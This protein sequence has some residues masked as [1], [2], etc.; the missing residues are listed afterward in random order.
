MDSTNVAGL[1]VTAPL[2]SCSS[3]VGALRARALRGEDAVS[4]AAARR[5]GLRTA[6]SKHESKAQSQRS[7]IEE[8]EIGDV[9][10]REL[11]GLLALVVE[12]DV[13]DFD[14]IWSCFR[15]TG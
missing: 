8:G 14:L 7:G 2:N 11:Y 1:D 4:S 10:T 15:F 13:L 5:V 12:V 6:V 3:Q 9:N